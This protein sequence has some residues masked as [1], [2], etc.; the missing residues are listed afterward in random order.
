MPI[1]AGQTISQPYIVAAM[2]AA[3]GIGPDDR[4][5][6]VGAGSGYAAALAGRLGKNV[7]AI[8]RIETLACAA[9]ERLARLGFDNVTLRSGDGSLG[10]ADMAPF[11][12]ILVAASAPA[13]PDALKRQLAV[14]G[15]LILPVGARAGAQRLLRIRRRGAE[16]F[17]EEEL[18]GVAFVPL[19][20]EAGWP[21]D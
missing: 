7:L 2:L 6:E 3:A 19:I 20:G 10:A 1:G 12:V 9:R 14:G 4:V 15:R 8:E 18:E 11:D 5:L 13:V 16:D 21:A 17:V